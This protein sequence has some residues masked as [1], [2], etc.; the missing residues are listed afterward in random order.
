MYPF[1][2]LPRISQKT[3]LRHGQYRDLVGS[4]R[5]VLRRAAIHKRNRAAGAHIR[6]DVKVHFAGP[7]VVNA[8]DILHKRGPKFGTLIGCIRLRKGLQAK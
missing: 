8:A 6:S 5:K 7:V 4:Y 1:R 2:K 3:A